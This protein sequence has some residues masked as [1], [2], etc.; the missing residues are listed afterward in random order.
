M[1]DKTKNHLVIVNI[2]MVKNG[3]RGRL[4]IETWKIIGDILE[5][6]K[7]NIEHAFK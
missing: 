7:M 6:V 2:M 4:C 5:I 3:D 1:H